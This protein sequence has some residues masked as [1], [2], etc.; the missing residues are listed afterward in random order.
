[1][2]PL[3]KWSGRSSNSSTKQETEPSSIIRLLLR[4]RYT[5]LGPAGDYESS[6]NKFTLFGFGSARQP[7]L[8]HDHVELESQER[9]EAADQVPKMRR[10]ASTS[11][12]RRDP[13]PRLQRSASTSA[14]RRT[15]VQKFGDTYVD[16]IWSAAAHVAKPGNPKR[17]PPT[18][19]MIFEKMF[20]E[21]HTTVVINQSLS[22][23]HSELVRRQ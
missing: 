19:A 7:D 14:M 12:A 9:N 8:N 15:V 22:A 20:G 18:R 21:P 13:A 23:L 1:M 4:K 3:P 11:Y 5:K 10:S 16:L 2:W 6:G 17:V